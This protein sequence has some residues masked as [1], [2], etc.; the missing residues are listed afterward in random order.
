MSHH[1]RLFDWQWGTGPVVSHEAGAT[2]ASPYPSSIPWP[3][4][5]M[6]EIDSAQQGGGS[7]RI[8]RIADELCSAALTSDS[9]A[10]QQDSSIWSLYSC[11]CCWAMNNA[12]TLTNVMQDYEREGTQGPWWH[13]TTHYIFRVPIMPTW[14]RDSI[15]CKRMEL[16]LKVHTFVT[17]KIRVKVCIFLRRGVMVGDCFSCEE[18]H[19]LK[20]V[21]NKKDI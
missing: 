6:Q 9:V 8:S 17:D 10:R 20:R 19:I 15:F 18:K 12:N 14:M 3:S 21:P 11:I 5:R 16:R 1:D 13:L 4:L 2:H 7:R